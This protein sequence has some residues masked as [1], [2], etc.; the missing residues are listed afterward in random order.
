MCQMD[1]HYSGEACRCHVMIANLQCVN[2]LE[3][4]RRHVPTLWCRFSCGRVGLEEFG[5]E[6]V[7][8]AEVFE[9][10]GGGV[11]FEGGGVGGEGIVTAHHTL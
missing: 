2:A 7:V 9:V 4:C 5:A 8:V 1:N 11:G 3:T 10:G 6:G